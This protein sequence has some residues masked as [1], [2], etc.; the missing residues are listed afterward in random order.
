MDLIAQLN[1]LHDLKVAP[2][3]RCSISTVLTVVTDD[4]RE[5]LL[6]ALD[7]P[8]IRHTDLANV[9]TRLGYPI[10]GVTVS[11]H[12]NRGESNGCRCPR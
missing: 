7:N 3:S 11:R 8:Q 12:R 9:L 1:D 2:T 4:E 6:K 10:K 5:A